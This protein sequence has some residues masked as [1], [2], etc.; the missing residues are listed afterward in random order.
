MK[1]VLVR[2][3][4]LV[5]EMGIFLLLDRILPPPTGLPPNGRFGGKGR[6]VHT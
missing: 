5:R 4:F 6:R 3:V 1:L 2:G